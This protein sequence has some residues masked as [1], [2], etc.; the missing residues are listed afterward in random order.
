MAT[1]SD[2]E[3][4][5]A[6]DNSMVMA[7]NAV[8]FYRSRKTNKNNKIFNDVKICT[9][10]KDDRPDFYRPPNSNVFAP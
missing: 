6:G 5:A 2:T 10:E 7:R 4:G 3:A 1:V 9:E 8:I